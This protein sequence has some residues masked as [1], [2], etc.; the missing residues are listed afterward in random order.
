MEGKVEASS[1]ETVRARKHKSFH[2]VDGRVSP[3]GGQVF[4]EASKAESESVADSSKSRLI[5]PPARRGQSRAQE[6]GDE[7]TSQVLVSPLPTSSS[8]IFIEC[9]ARV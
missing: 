9:H 8:T 3:C 5:R 4:R 7:A 6:E 2:L 1:W